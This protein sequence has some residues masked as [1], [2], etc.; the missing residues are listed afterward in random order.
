MKRKCQEENV[1][2]SSALNSF[3]RKFCGKCGIFLSKTRIYRSYPCLCHIKVHCVRSVDGSAC[4]Y[5]C[6][7]GRQ[8]PLDSL[9]NSLQWRWKVFFGF[10][11]QSLNLTLLCDHNIP[12]FII[13]INPAW[14]SAPLPWHQAWA[15]ARRVAFLIISG[16]S[17]KLWTPLKSICGERHAGSVPWIPLPSVKCCQLGRSPKLKQLQKCRGKQLGL[18]PA[19][20]FPQVE[21][22][23]RVRSRYTTWI[24]MFTLYQSFTQDLAEQGT[25]R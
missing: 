8:K 5:F 20:D 9:V 7:T 24:Y 19:P 10:R 25:L 14:L 11:F 13:Q 18:S 16:F 23:K 15:L 2:V 17:S 4:L 6:G 22:L 3:W 21:S 1:K 12:P